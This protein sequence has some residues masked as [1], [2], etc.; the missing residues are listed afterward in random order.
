MTGEW[1][2]CK[3]GDVAEIVGGGTPNT[4]E[5]K[6]WNG[7][8]AWLTP[9]DLSYFNGRY[10]S[11]GERNISKLGLAKSSAK[12]LPKGSV[13]LS[14]RAPVGY[15]AIALNEITTNQGFR[16]L[17]PNSNTDNL[18]LYYLLKNNVEYLK[19]Q[20][21]G[22][23]FIELSGSTLKS[24]SFL[25]PSLPEQ[26]AIASVLSSLDDKI[27]L[28]H[29][30]NK[31]LEAMA[32]TLFRQWFVEEADEDWEEGFLPDEFDFT[33]GQSPPGTSYNQ[34]GVGKPMFQG[35]ADF[36][37]RFPEE[38]VYTTEPTRLAYPHDT[39][40][41]VRAPVGAQNMAKVECCIGRGVSAFRY[42]ANNDFYTYTYFKLRSL[43]DEIKKFN[44]EGTVF[45][46]I[47]KTDFLQMGIAIP[48]EDIIEKFEIHAKP[49][50][51]KVIENCIQIKLLE[52]MRD[53]LLPKLM[54]GEV[55][56]EG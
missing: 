52:V 18:F 22:T 33:M 13:L 54:S 48:P 23:T 25:F 45:G 47:S 53:T 8:I 56:V 38:R 21:T 30:Q 51:D 27:D 20:S 41:S 49:L 6:Y 28:L 29:R 50:N 11:K 39:L 44:D 35:N 4:N 15:L 55:R 3:L 10:I 2:E 7:E 5:S 12:I 46:S 26:R 37:F 24:L 42:K 9:R 43:M 31:T 14:S 34:E 16:S 19:S 40:I 32:E 17:I 1:K 36:G